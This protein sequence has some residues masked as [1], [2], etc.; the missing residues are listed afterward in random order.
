MGDEVTVIDSEVVMV[1]DE[2][3]MVDGDVITIDHDIGVEQYEMEKIQLP[4]KHDLT[5]IEQY[6]ANFTLT[7]H[8]APSLK[9][10]LEMYVKHSKWAEHAWKAATKNCSIMNGQRTDAQKAGVG[11]RQRRGVFEQFFRSLTPQQLQAQCELYGIEVYGMPAS[12]D[13]NAN[14]GRQVGI[15]VVELQ[16][17]DIREYAI[18]QLC[19]AYENV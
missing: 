18:A 6:I 12:N 4:E 14:S 7:R 5:G 3:I 17:E 1:D 2:V 9:N 16:Y 11:K 13:A 8:G 19:K 15:T 10:N